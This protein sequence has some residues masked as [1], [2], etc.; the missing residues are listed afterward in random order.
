MSIAAPEALD[1]TAIPWLF[2]VALATT[3]PHVLH[4]S[5]HLSAFALLMLGWSVWLW[6]HARRLPSRWLIVL[7]TLFAAIAVLVEFRTL[8]GREAGIALLVLFTAL[9]LLEI[10]SRRDAYVSIMLAY[11]VLLTHFFDSESIFTGLWLLAS[12]V[13]VTATLIR[14]HGGPR[15]HILPTLRLAGRMTLQSLPLMIV[16]Y[17]LFP[18]IGGPLWGMPK[19]AYTARTGLTD[20]MAPGSISHLVQSG[21]IALRARFD[22]PLPERS[23]LYW[24]GPVLDETDG[25]TWRM[26]PL[27]TSIKA[28]VIESDAPPVTYTLTLEAHQQRWLL[29]LDAPAKAPANARI[30]PVMTVLAQQPVRQRQRHEMTAQTRYRFNVIEAPVTLKRALLLPPGR[31]PRTR[32]LAEEWRRSDPRPENLVQRALTHFRQEKFFYTLHPPILG[33]EPTDDFL[34]LSRR[35][36]CEHYAA[37]FVT[38]MRA[39]GVPAR[40]IGGYQ[41]GE[42]NPVDN[43]LIVRQSD[44]HA[45]AEVWLEGRGWV[46]IDPTAAVSPSRIESGI[47]AAMSADEPLPTLIQIDSDWLKGLRNRWEAINNGWNQWVL[48]YNADRQRDLLHSLGFENPQWQTFGSLLLGVFAVFF[49]GVSAW[50]LYQRPRI[51]PARQLWDQALRQLRRHRIECAE[52]E[53]PLALAG[54][55]QAEH[56][57]VGRAMAEVARHYLA[58]RYGRGP[59]NLERL[60]QAVDDLKS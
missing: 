58:A 40:V 46:R 22:G 11:F 20:Q 17:L 1:R 59:I 53:A 2:A 37:A 15:H 13:L 25:S 31:N 10:R 56:P 49:F 54:R 21:E 50:I 43:H 41:G 3:L 29:A 55:L 30:S 51:D 18:R 44:A 27:P 47:A 48:G 23:K 6:W 60:R 57:E 24:R 36:F 16:L 34:F 5:I 35:G 12:V 28:P 9:K 14:L 33:K 42:L 39:A 8:F 26:A 38:L 19:D 7:C 45:W 32:A 4:L 52:W